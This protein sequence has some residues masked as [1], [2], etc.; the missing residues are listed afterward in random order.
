MIHHASSRFSSRLVLLQHSRRC[1]SRLQPA[2]HHRSPNAVLDDADLEP[3]EKRAI[4]SAWA[5]DLYAVECCPWL[6]EVPGLK[7]PLRLADI[8]E[9]LRA[10]DEEDDPPRGGASSRC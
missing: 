9:A 1:C 7:G 3:F 6:R 8:L 5:S 2:L 10:L 4:L